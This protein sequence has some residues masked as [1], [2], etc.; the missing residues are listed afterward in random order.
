[1]NKVKKQYMNIGL[2][3]II[4]I[5]L[6]AGPPFSDTG[7]LPSFNLM[8]KAFPDAPAYLTDFVMG[9]ASLFAVPAGIIAGFLAEYVSK[10]KIIFFTHVMFLVSAVFGGI[11]ENLWYIAV[12][13]AINGMA[14]GAMTTVSLGLIAEL[15]PDESECGKMMGLYNGVQ[16]GQ[17]IIM[18]LAGGILAT[19][20]WTYP[21]YMFA[22]YI[23]LLYLIYRY[24]PESKIVNNSKNSSCGNLFSRLKGMHRVFFLCLAAFA[25]SCIYCTIYMEIS[26]YV[27]ERGIGNA[28]IAGRISAF[29]TFGSLTA[30]LIFPYFYNKFRRFL[31][32]FYSIMLTGVFAVFS[33]NEPVIILCIVWFIAG[34][35]YSIAI[36]YYFTYVTTLCDERDSSLALSFSNCAV[37]LGMFFSVYFVSIC[38]KIFDTDLIIELIPLFTVILLI[39]SALSLIF[40]LYDQKITKKRI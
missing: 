15:W 21:F 35:C 37:N 13:R 16:A 28:D 10:K 1:M 30:G 4:T 8:H 7:I 17:G 9:A 38:K 5:L 3:T 25:V 20:K 18:S 39:I 32:V 31:P 36:S 26:I 6:T 22:A 2:I 11:I 12:M 33:G 19:I 40:S 24:I 23:P 14:Y 29:G 27:A 34:N